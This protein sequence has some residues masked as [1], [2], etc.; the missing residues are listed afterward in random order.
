[1]TDYVRYR[2]YVPQMKEVTLCAWIET[3][4]FQNE[5]ESVVSYATSS[6]NNVLLFYFEAQAR[7]AFRT[8]ASVSY[9]S[10]PNNLHKVNKN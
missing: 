6:E 8:A 1:M 9:F 5:V 10:I 7:I 3:A 4:G 2:S